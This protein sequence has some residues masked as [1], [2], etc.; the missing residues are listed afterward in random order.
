MPINYDNLKLKTFD[1]NKLLTILV[2]FMIF[3]L[4]ACEIEKTEEPSE[5][6]GMGNAEGDL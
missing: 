3:M 6:P 1:M 4:N 5:I 2:L